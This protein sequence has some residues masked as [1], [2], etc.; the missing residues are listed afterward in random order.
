VRKRK[1][2]QPAEVDIL[3]YNRSSFV[4]GKAFINTQKAV[5]NCEEVDTQ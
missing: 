4:Y 5:K 2:D 3:V 1:V